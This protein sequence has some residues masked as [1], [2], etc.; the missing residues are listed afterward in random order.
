MH[1]ERADR[2]KVEHGEE[3]RRKRDARGREVVKVREAG[4]SGVDGG[5][6]CIRISDGWIG[7]TRRLLHLDEHRRLECLQRGCGCKR[8]EGGASVA[9][10]WKGSCRRC[11]RK[12]VGEGRTF[13]PPVLHI[14]GVGRPLTPTASREPVTRTIISWPCNRVFGVYVG[15]E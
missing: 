7:E 9:S 15:I 12:E 10:T 5:L 14:H 2:G 11:L 6:R 8:V 1:R 13:Y 3:L 4:C